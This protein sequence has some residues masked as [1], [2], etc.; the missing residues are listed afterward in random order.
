[1]SYLEEIMMAGRGVFAIIFGRRDASR[2]FRLDLAGLMGSLIALLVVE[3]AGAFL[4]AMMGD[5]GPLTAAQLVLSSLVIFAMQV[6]GAA[7]VLNQIGRLDA[8]IP[9]MVT[10]NWASVFISLIAV[11]LTLL[12]FDPAVLQV[13]LVVVVLAVLINIGRVIMTLRPLQIAALM[14]VM[15]ISV[16]VGLT[17]IA[18]VFPIDP[19]ILGD[20]SA[21]Q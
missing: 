21:I 16:F 20:G 8:F 10:D 19:A 3:G 11:V 18:L 1:M 4:P 6:G 14:L 5:P 12:G 9:Y 7:I 2:Y 17:F 13:V 15:L